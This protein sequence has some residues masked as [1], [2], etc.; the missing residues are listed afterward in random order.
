[1]K[2][3]LLIL[4]LI[5]SFVSL[6]QNQKYL[7]L[8][9]AL[10]SKTPVR[11]L[12]LS[13]DSTTMQVF[14]EEAVNFTDLAGLAVEG[15]V[16]NEASFWEAV[17][18]FNILEQLILINNNLRKIKLSTTT[19]LKDL[20]I[21]GSPKLSPV[22]LNSTIYECRYLQ[23]L[24]LHNLK[25]D[26]IPGTITQLR[27]L[28]H[29]EIIDS[30]WSFNSIVS[31]TKNLP[32]L[33]K[34]ILSNNNFENIGT[35][36]MNLQKV[37]YLDLS[38]NNIREVSKKIKKLP[39]LDTLVLNYNRDLNINEYTKVLD[40]IELDFLAIDS[41][42]SNLNSEIEFKIMGPEIVWTND[43]I[44]KPEITLP[45]GQV[46]LEKSFDIELISNKIENTLSSS[47]EMAKIYSPAFIRYEQLKFPDPLSK[48]DTAMFDTRYS[49]RSYMYTE[50]IEK[51]NHNK[52]G[53]YNILVKNKGHESY[54]T[55]KYRLKINHKRHSHI[56]FN[57]FKTDHPKYQN[58]VLIQVQVAQF[59]DAKRTDFDAFRDI[60]W[61]LPMF[62]EYNQFK[63]RYVKNKS[64]SDIRVL[65]DTS[66]NTYSF[67]LKGRF[68]DKEFGVVP[69]KR[70]KLYDP[71]FLSR[72]AP[73]IYERYAKTLGRESKKFDKTLN[74]EMSK[75]ERPYTN[76]LKVKWEEVQSYMTEEEV[77]MS[78]KEWLNYY[79]NINGKEMAT[80]ANNPLQP[81]YLS[82][83]LQSKGFTYSQGQDFYVAQ[84]WTD[85]NISSSSN[86]TLKIKDFTLVDLER[87]LVRYFAPKENPEVL[88]DGY[89]KYMMIVRL[90]DGQLLK[91][92]RGEFEILMEEK[93]FQISTS[94]NMPFMQIKDAANLIIDEAN[95]IQY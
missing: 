34:L 74:R 10:K 50:K 90:E 55:T 32:D 46:I 3:I 19:T 91:I 62:D 85:F 54:F 31:L 72:N 23:S 59:E 18:N 45:N 80:I 52:N 16:Q 57:E 4:A 37:K 56:L 24:K 43:T 87:R 29:F 41:T 66:T 38:N 94:N 11:Y 67:L 71:K 73:K 48:I 9:Q 60:V 84:K 77:N 47:N 21:S 25:T 53:T 7:S 58:K 28:N 2:S 64:W 44:N 65:R 49:D 33:K 13:T 51:Q 79:K 26:S 82:R 17:S 5:T 15:E 89:H 14:E 42:E 6:A 27:L 83:F 92:N 63:E 75:M 40:K 81:I 88:V 22:L 36:V 35:T 20:W 1:M 39:N 78:K 86:D 70:T 68:G 69:R 30:Q 76:E 12:Y 93:E 95:K 61:E 8:S